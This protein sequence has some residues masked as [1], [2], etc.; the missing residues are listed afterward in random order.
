MCN[1]AGYAGNKQAAPI[2]G[3]ILRRQQYYDGNMSAGIVTY[4]E[5][6]LH[7][8]R[9]TGPVEKLLEETDALELPGT[10]GIAHTRPAPSAVQP[11]MSKDETIALATNGTTC[12][13][14]HCAN[15]DAAATL[16]DESGFE[17]GSWREDDGKHMPHPKVARTNRIVS[18]MEVRYGIFAYWL[19]RG[20]SPEEALVHAGEAMYKDNASVILTLRF[21]DRFF[22]LRT[23]RSLFAATK[24]GE[25]FLATAKLGL[26]EEVRER[27]FCLPLFHA[28]T[29]TRE[30]VTISPHRMQ[31]EEVS[32]MTPYTYH[33]AYRR[34][35]KI[36][37]SER[38][39]LYFD[40]LEFAAGDM[41]DI[42]PGN[43]TFVQNARLVYDILE[44]FEREGRLKKELR[45]QER[46]GRIRLRWYFRLDD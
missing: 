41:R 3:E 12:T 26:P 14:K 28:C 30:G 9:A 19:D 36:L 17:F 42:W 25:T 38:A 2:L 33:E 39:P 34:F 4:H 20:K 1:I 23:T 32:E 24:D 15:W 13:T 46:S 8:R 45:E 22:A 18:T 31:I 37:R 5:G 7:C 6:K 40:E 27:G 29:L 43:H 21:P 11:V 16:L 10:I 44:Q 35:E